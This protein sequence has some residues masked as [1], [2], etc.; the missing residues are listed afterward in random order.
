V[1]G[2]LGSFL[3]AA[4][5]SDDSLAFRFLLPLPSPREDV[6]AGTD[7]PVAIPLGSSDLEGFEEE[8]RRWG[9]CKMKLEA[10]TFGADAAREVSPPAP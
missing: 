6:D 10:A 5:R 3:K 7:W 1:L 2:T 8:N 4:S 9:R